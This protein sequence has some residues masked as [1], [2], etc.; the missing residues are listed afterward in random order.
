VPNPTQQRNTQLLK[1][2]GAAAI[3]ALAWAGMAGMHVRPVWL[4]IVIAL[5]VGVLAA[6]NTEL[7]VLLA[8]AGLCLP[9]LAVSPIAGIVI[10]LALFFA[11]RYLGGRGAT[12]FILI[13]VA[14]IGAYFGPLWAAA[15]LAGYLL[16]PVEGA[17][18][19]GVACLATELLGML[20]AHPSIGALITG[21][22]QPA[23]VSFAKMPQTFLSGAWVMK[24]LQSISPAAVEDFASTFA[25]IGNPAILLLQ[26]AVWVA[27]AAASGLIARRIKGQPRFLMSLAGTAAGVAVLWIGSSLAHLALKAPATG[28]NTT[29]VL[30]SSAVAALAFVAIR[31]T[32]FPPGSFID[33][34]STAYPTSMAAEDADVDELLRL[35]STAEDKLASKH[36]SVRTVLITDMKSFSRITEEDGSVATA[37]T[38][39]RHRDL[40]VPVISANHGSG[41]STG[42]DGVVAAF[43]SAADALKAAIQG[44]DALATYNAS[45]PN[46]R[47]IWVRMGLASGEVVLDKGG[48]PFIGAGLNLAARVMNLADGGQVFATADVGSAAPAA[49][50]RTASF[51]QFELKNIAEPVEITEILWKDDQ[52]PRDPRAEPSPQQP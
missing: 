50:A 19:A 44:Q 29:I 30:G 34:R 2:F 3:A 42:G 17:V 46:E 14:L 52:V 23:A 49:K 31:E 48:R 21:G 38:I 8:L 27:A 43:E 1:W 39:Q 7:G 25:H 4:P 6:I 37:K 12:V 32:L 51:G 36:T 41:K 16:G 11:E 22:Q 10:T 5:G 40:L 26:V 13:G 15:A 45:H 20:T 18:A 9:I 24:S 33:A 35:I 47:E 28:A